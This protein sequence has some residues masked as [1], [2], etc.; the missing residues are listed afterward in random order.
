MKNSH[1]VRQIRQAHCRQAQYKKG[2]IAP[3]LLALITL[4]LIGGGAYVYVQKNQSNQPVTATSTTKTVIPNDKG[5]NGEDHTGSGAQA[6]LKQQTAGWKM[7]TNSQYGFSF[8]YPPTLLLKNESE[9][10]SGVNPH[11]WW[12]RFQN[13]NGKDFEVNIT[14]NTLVDINVVSVHTKF[15]GDVKTQSMMIGV[16]KGIRFDTSDE[17]GSVVTIRTSIGAHELQIAFDASYSELIDSIL[18]TFKFSTSSVQTSDWKTYTNSQYGYQINYPQ[19]ASISAVEDEVYPGLDVTI[20]NEGG[21]QMTIS[22]RS[23][24]KTLQ[25]YLADYDSRSVQAGTAVELNIGNLQAFQRKE[26]A[27][28]PGWD[29]IVTYL[30]KGSTVVIFMLGGRYNYTNKDIALYNQILSTFK[31]NP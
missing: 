13:A 4:L 5:T 27:L 9:S 11:Q 24:D 31:F 10:L 17:A 15:N 3:L 2:F 19:T 18:S 12:I 23:S 28:G 1:H 30:K 20:K 21:F 14:E 6:L 26:V 7:Y 22:T 8:Q 25:Q 29:N 16:K